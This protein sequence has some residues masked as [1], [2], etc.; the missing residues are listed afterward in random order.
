MARRYFTIEEANTLLPELRVIL[1][2]L[3]ARRR[4]LED[5]QQA[6]EAIR[7]QAGENGYRLGGDEFLHLKREAEF[8]LEECNT[9]I[10]KIEALGCLLKDLHLGL[11]DF[12][13]LREGQ[14]VFLCWK[15]DEAEVAHWHS[16]T[17][18]FAGRKPIR[19]HPIS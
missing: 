3:Q 10:T 17:E 11:I 7:H 9:A 16:L 5:R 19:S 15:P 18:G 2:Q 13:S 4:E 14:E 6:L 12:P 8:I 1:E